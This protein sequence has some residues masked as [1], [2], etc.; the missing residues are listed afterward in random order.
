MKQKLTKN[1][2]GVFVF[3]MNMALFLLLTAPFKLWVAASE[4]TQMRPAAALTPVLGMIF[5]WTAA[6]GCATGNLICDLMAG[7]EVFYAVLNSLLQILYAMSAYFVWKK[8]NRERGGKE[9]RLDS[10]A[11]ILKFCVLLVFNALL[12]V[13]CTSILNHAYDVTD[14]ISLDNFFVFVNSFDSGLLFGAPLLILGHLL[15]MQIENMKIGN[16][17]RIIH[18]SMNERIILN[19][20]I[21]G[22]CIC[23][24][25]GTSV[26]LTDKLGAT[27]S[28]GIWSR[29]YLFETLA[30]NTY[31]A[32]SIGFM[33]FTER[34]IS[35]PIEQL[36]QIVGS[37]YAKRVTD[38]ERERMIDACGVYA[39]DST[40][41][42]ELA[43]SYISMVRDLGKYVENLQSVMA[44]KERINA[45]LTLAS[46]IQAHML[47]SI[48]PPFPEH[49]EFD[50]YAIM[51][52]AKEVGGDFYDFFMVGE[53]RLAII[54]ADV[55]GKGVPAA[56]FMVITKTL[57]KNYTQTGMQPAEVFTTVNRILCDGNDAGLF[58]TAWMGVLEISNGTL[59]YVNAGHN[60][61]LIKRADGG[62]EYLRERTGFVLAGMDNM[63][64]RQ[65][66]LLIKPDDR[67]FLYTDG[68]TETTDAQER[69]Y[70]EEQLKAF[71]N[72]H[73]SCDA[74][75]LL[76]ELQV[77]LKAFAGTAPQFDDTTMLLLDFKGERMVERTFEAK[78]EN[79]AKML[80]FVGGE[81]E[82]SGCSSK[83]QD[84]IC[85]AMEEIF[86][87]IAH[88]AYPDGSGTA[89]VAIGID[90]KTDVATFVVSDTGIP[91]NPLE[92]VDPDITLSA[93]QREIGGLGI[94]IIKK[95][96]NSVVYSCENGENKLTMT[97]K[98]E[99]NGENDNYER[100]KQQ[101]DGSAH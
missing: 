23:V 80:D 10:V 65:K 61:P 73:L 20:L 54:V 40:E 32:L 72:S 34:R 90:D 68:V 88:Y 70:G 63:E 97:K 67:M 53:D 60:P 85:V 87:N 94:F 38:A 8:L 78:E 82:K 84:A 2:A 71:L 30:M 51:H 81:L 41:V 89:K 18:F 57:I 56:L 74:T 22:L 91:F 64:Y 66:T 4:I 15:Q 48:F 96:M 31:F 49:S 6:L 35:R 9:F 24:L 16:E 11:R 3:L 45:E 55:S 13:I 83:M 36:T 17:E 77:D 28:V 69:L 12:T 98:L 62:F 33:C 52:P 75:E 21:T 1:S 99:R 58:V 47:P 29:I 76:Q 92:R 7:Y 43:R 86:V 95:T 42:G 5:G 26:Y 101:D 59:T 100:T 37:Y 19:T 27:S 39:K 79:I 25:V 44:E 50:V 93:E 46:D 14:I